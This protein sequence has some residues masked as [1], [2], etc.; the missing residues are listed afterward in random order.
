MKVKLLAVLVLV[1]GAAN[2]AAVVDVSVGPYFGMDIPVVNDRA[3]SGTLFGLQGKL[4]VTSFLGVGAHYSS[5]S[6]GDVDHTFFEDE[7][8][9]FSE[10]LPGGDASSFG[11][12]AYLG[13]LS[14]VPGFKLYL[15]GSLESWKWERDYT[16]DLSEIAFGVGPGAEFVLPMGLGIEGR[17][18]F[19]VAPTDGGGSVKSFLWFVG[20]N[21]HFFSLLK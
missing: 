20:V 9:E 2:A 18:M 13:L 15:M 6:L 4:F 12:D 3:K 11:V 19:R 21:Y 1:L 5:S 10:S 17:G 7:P 16:D 8:E 14:G